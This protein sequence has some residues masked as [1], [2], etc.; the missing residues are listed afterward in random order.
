MAGKSAMRVVFSGGTGFINTAIGKRLLEMGVDRTLLENGRR[1]GLV[2]VALSCQWIEDD[3]HCLKPERLRERIPVHLHAQLP[4]YH[5][6]WFIV[7]GRGS[8]D[9]T[10]VE[11]LKGIVAQGPA[12][13]GG[14]GLSLPR[15][16]DRPVKAEL[17]GE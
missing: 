16:S 9:T 7:M 6:G 5:H 10:K 11:H 15:G 14:I 3:P 4:H 12:G 8:D 13:F 17:R 1:N 2:N